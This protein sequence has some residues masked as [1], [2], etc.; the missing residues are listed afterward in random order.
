MRSF[1]G[2]Y[3]LKNSRMCIRRLPHAMV[4]LS[5]VSGPALAE[6]CIPPPRPFVP[7]DPKVAS[8]YVDIIRNDFDLYFRDIQSYF[9]CL[10]EERTRAFKEAREVSEE[11]GRFLGSV[12][13]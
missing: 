8:E 12:D 4:L 6:S 2:I 1:K 5:L 11:Y 7:S 13:R 9:R 10:D 3:G